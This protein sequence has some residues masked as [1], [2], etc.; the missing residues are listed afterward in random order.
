M[1][2]QTINFEQPRP[3]IAVHFPDAEQAENLARVSKN[4]APHVLAFFAARKP[5]DEF[6]MNDLADYVR[7]AL[8]FVVVESAGRIMRDL[9]TAKALNYEVV[10][11]ARSLYRVLEMEAA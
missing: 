10:S 11:R 2:Q 4:I 9:R 5:G 1:Q 7:G 8:P 6:R 3:Y